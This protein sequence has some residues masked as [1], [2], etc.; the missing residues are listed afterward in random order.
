MKISRN[1]V[2]KRDFCIGFLYCGLDLCEHHFLTLFFHCLLWRIELGAS[3][4]FF[5][6][7]FFFFFFRF[8]E[9]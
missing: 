1:L 8:G 2:S 3:E 4:T 6:L 9:R 5:S 7:S